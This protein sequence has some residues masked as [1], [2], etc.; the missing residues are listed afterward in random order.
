[1]HTGLEP[2]SPALEKWKLLHW[3]HLC[4]PHGLYGPCNSSGQDTS[5]PKNQI[6]VS[7]I[8]GGFFIGLVTREAQEYWGE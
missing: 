1:M 5:Q 4:D 7:C 6:Q 2:K 3:V 8:A